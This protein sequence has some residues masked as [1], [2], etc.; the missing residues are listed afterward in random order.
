MKYKKYIIFAIIALLFISVCIGCSISGSSKK[1]NGETTQPVKVLAEAQ[2][3]DIMEEAAENEITEYVYID[4]DNDGNKEL[5][6]AYLNDKSMC[7]AWYCNST[8]TVCEKVHES[9]IWTDACTLVTHKI[10]KE[11]H[12]FVNMHR[13]AGNSIY[14][15]VLRKNGEKVESIVE[16]EFGNLIVA[17]NGD[18]QLGIEAY[19]GMYDAGVKV[20]IGHTYKVTYLHYDKGAYKEYGAVEIPEEEFLGY[21]NASEIKKQIEQEITNDST[22]KIEFKYYLRSNGYM[23]VQADEY[24]NRGNIYYA[25]YTYKVTRKSLNKKSQVRY[26]GRIASFLSTLQ[27]TY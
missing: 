13:A 15:S 18:L 11:T 23:H 4:M 19:D 7:Y 5:I 25:H 9:H 2:L 14:F 22:D 17:D 6:G 21:D 3:L 8:G 12:V 1:N 24:D 16:N 20:D 10:K 27:V 26:D